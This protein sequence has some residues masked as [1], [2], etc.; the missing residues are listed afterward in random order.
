V[1]QGLLVAA[2]EDRQ[3]AGEGVRPAADV[4]DVALDPGDVV[5]L[6]VG[7]LAGSDEA[8]RVD[9]EMNHRLPPVDVSGA[10]YDPIGSS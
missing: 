4:P 1:L 5:E 6:A 10:E 7:D 9:L 8:V 2:E 3:D